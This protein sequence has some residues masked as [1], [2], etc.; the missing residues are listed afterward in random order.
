M[1]AAVPAAVPRWLRTSPRDPPPGE[2]D[3]W[4]SQFPQISACDLLPSGADPAAIASLTARGACSR[5]RN[6]SPDFLVISRLLLACAPS[7]GQYNDTDLRMII[8][9]DSCDGTLLPMIQHELIVRSRHEEWT[10]RWIPTTDV[11]ETGVYH[12]GGSGL[13]GGPVSW[14]DRST[15]STQGS[16]RAGRAIASR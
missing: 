10:R 5:K 11:A 12:S 4:G 3:L 6:H 8:G 7:A 13:E 16:P 15:G 14:L 1:P 9:I 2:P